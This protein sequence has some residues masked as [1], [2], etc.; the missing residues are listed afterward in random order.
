MSL[1]IEIDKM[2]VLIANVSWQTGGLD[3]VFHGAGL[4]D[5]LMGESSGCDAG[6]DGDLP[7]EGKECLGVN[8]ALEMLRQ[9]MIFNMNLSCIGSHTISKR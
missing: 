2:L 9:I 7:Q 4:T 5:T 6:I 1:Y 8:Q 3:Q